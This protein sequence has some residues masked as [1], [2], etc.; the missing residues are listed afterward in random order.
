MHTA[1]RSRVHL[2][3]QKAYRQCC[4]S[5]T[6]SRRP[7]PLSGKGRRSKPLTRFVSPPGTLFSVARAMGLT[8]RMR[9]PSEVVPSHPPSP[10]LTTECGEKAEGVLS[11]AVKSQRVPPRMPGPYSNRYS[12][13]VSDKIIIAAP[14]CIFIGRTCTYVR[15]QGQRYR[16]DCVY[17]P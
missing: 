8:F 1:L 7:S 10:C 5:F 11:I 2:P 17:H 12:C 4:R 16:R 6:P 3:V 13:T 9:S 15:R 14:C